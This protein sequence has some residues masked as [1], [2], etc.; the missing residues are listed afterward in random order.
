G[1]APGRGS[2]AA[3]MP[4]TRH[5]CLSAHSLQPIGDDE[6]GPVPEPERGC[7]KPFCLAVVHALQGA[8]HGSLPSSWASLGS[9]ACRTPQASSAGNPTIDM[10]RARSPR[11]IAQNLVPD[12][13]PT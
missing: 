4:A 13:T 12:M 3:E 1:N 7:G 9:S 6:P 2:P 8:V 5:G 10:P 11:L